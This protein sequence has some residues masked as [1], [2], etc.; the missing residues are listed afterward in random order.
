MLCRC[1]QRCWEEESRAEIELEV[2]FSNP[3]VCGAGYTH[4]HTRRHTMDGGRLFE[5]CG[6]GG[7]RSM[8]DCEERGGRMDNDLQ[9]L[10]WN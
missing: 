10:V 7:Q 5:P 2:K 6:G 1:L 9:A 4:T 3:V 8:V